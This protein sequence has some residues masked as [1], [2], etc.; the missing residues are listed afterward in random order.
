MAFA[1]SE[2][3]QWLVGFF[4]AVAIAE[5]GFTRTQTRSRALEPA[6]GASKGSPL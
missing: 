5:V 1:M 4:A 3:Y 6:E 2:T